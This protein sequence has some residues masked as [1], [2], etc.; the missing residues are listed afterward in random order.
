VAA[1]AIP[2]LK[3]LRRSGSDEVKMYATAALGGLGVGG[4]GHCRW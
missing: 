1:G 2:R 3:E 4:C